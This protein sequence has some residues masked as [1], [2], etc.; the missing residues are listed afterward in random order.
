MNIN[1]VAYHII[2]LNYYFET[3]NKINKLRNEGGEIYNSLL[4]LSFL[5]VRKPPSIY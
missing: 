5:L 4:L 3:N 2:R 1:T